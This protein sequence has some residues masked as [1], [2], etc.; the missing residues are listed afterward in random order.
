M[1][2]CPKCGR[3]YRMTPDVCGDC[4]TPLADP[5]FPDPFAEAVRNE[6]ALREDARRRREA[7]L[8]PKIPVRTA[9][10]DDEDALF[11]EP[12]DAEPAAPAKPRRTGLRILAVT[13]ALAVAAGGWY[14]W[15]RFRNRNAAATLDLVYFDGAQPCFYD[16]Q[17][18]STYLLGAPIKMLEH[19]PDS[20]SDFRELFCAHTVLSEDRSRIFYPKYYTDGEDGAQ[21]YYDANGYDGS[22]D[23]SEPD[24]S[25]SA[26]DGLPT[27]FT[28]CCLNLTKKDAAEQVLWPLTNYYTETAMLE[29]VLGETKINNYTLL[30]PSGSYVLLYLGS[31]QYA[32]WKDP[33]VFGM[34]KGMEPFEAWEVIPTEQ[35]GKFLCAT[36]RKTEEGE[37][38]PVLLNNLSGSS[39][40][41][42]LDLVDVTSGGRRRLNDEQPSPIASFFSAEQGAQY[43]KRRYMFYSTTYAT[44][45]LPTDEYGITMQQGDCRIGVMM[46]DG[47][48]YYPVEPEILDPDELQRRGEQMTWSRTFYYGTAV[49]RFDLQTCQD[50][51]VC[52]DTE[53]I[54]HQWLGFPDGGFLYARDTAAAEGFDESYD[55]AYYGPDLKPDENASFRVDLNQNAMFFPS[56]DGSWF[57]YARPESGEAD[58]AREHHLFFKGRNIELL[59]LPDDFDTVFS[60]SVRQ[61]SGRILLQAWH[62]LDSKRYYTG[63]I[64]DADTVRMEQLPLIGG[65]VGFLGGEPVMLREED[66]RFTAELLNGPRITENADDQIGMFFTDEKAGALYFT[67]YESADDSLSSSYRKLCRYDRKSGQVTVI[68]DKVVA[69]SFRFDSENGKFGFIRFENS[70]QKKYAVYTGNSKTGT[71]RDCAAVGDGFSGLPVVRMPA[72]RTTIMD[73]P[74]YD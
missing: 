69:G 61:E 13:A 51:V 29:P 20:F 3:E 47:L 53:C 10:T 6:E 9:L 58:A 12:E 28:P 71:L 52:N 59:G 5:A 8:A 48:Q 66:G 60:V 18:G 64:T 72:S 37:E 46:Q 39:T 14:G 32:V 70:G 16:G 27:F 49:H 67:E 41:L 17:T 31:E 11:E 42:D 26:D 68:A 43:L 74:V 65:Q 55:L 7:R 24:D 15:R 54:S 4:G 25:Y 19:S 2:I 44:D 21:I 50:E 45:T 63:Q 22:E 35:D 30:G 34:S 38:E 56:T 1:T 62:M 23:S 33:A 73:A 57:Y 40:L 36:E